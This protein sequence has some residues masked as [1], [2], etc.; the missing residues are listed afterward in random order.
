MRAASLPHTYTLPPHCGS[1]YQMSRCWCTALP[2]CLRR[3][4]SSRSSP[5]QQQPHPPMHDDTP[6][7]MRTCACKHVC[8]CVMSHLRCLFIP[9]VTK[10][11]PGQPGVRALPP[12]AQRSGQRTVRT[13]L[14]VH[15]CAPRTAGGWRGRQAG[16]Q[17]GGWVRGLMPPR[18]SLLA[19][20]HTLKSP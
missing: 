16:R 2:A 12:Q 19:A 13:L 11:P 6:A 5:A 15:A 14:V 9:S 17:G 4:T 8:E 3:S 18:S 20:F 1:L 10:L 7:R